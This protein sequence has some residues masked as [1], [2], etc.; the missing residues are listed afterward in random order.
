M[1][2]PD[3]YWTSE[4][5]AGLSRAEI[6]NLR[7]N[8]LAQGAQ[9]IVQRCDSELSRG[10]SPKARRAKSSFLIDE[11]K[12]EE[13]AGLIEGLPPA[14]DV[15]L[16]AKRLQRLAEPV[17]TFSALWRQFIVCG[18]S[19]LEKS[20]PE[21][22]LG[23]FSRGSSPIL[24]LSAVLDHG[25]DGDWIAAQLARGGLNR[26]TTVKVG[27]VT[28]AREVFRTTVGHDDALANGRGAGS[29]LEVFLDL[30]AGR[31]SDRDL[32]ASAVF[33]ASLDPR[34]FKG[35]GHK[36]IRNILV[37]SGLAYNVVPLD[38]R[39]RAFFGST[40]EFTSTDLGRRPRYLAIEDLLRNALLR[41]QPVRSDIPNLAVLDA[42]AFASQSSLGH[43][44]GGWAGS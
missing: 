26:M 6:Q 41:V 14:A 30:A 31:S 25:A 16:A 27:L 40:L 32:A 15:P 18:F 23:A 4:R 29:P 7:A 35:I 17:T 44:V 10:R 11:N 22:P 34:A 21:T 3:D 8:A 13:V 5:I 9:T 1:D 42:I 36:Q 24:E 20:D 19:S 28:S 43:G 39:W 12:I 37:N 33:S 38:S 2:K